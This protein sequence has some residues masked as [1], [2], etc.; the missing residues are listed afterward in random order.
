MSESHVE[1]EIADPKERFDDVVREYID[2]VNQQVGAYM[3]ALAGFAGHYTRVERQVHRVIR[4]SRRVNPAVPADPVVWTSYEDPTQP[5]V[6]HNR[7]VRS[8]DYLAINARGGSNEQQQARATLVFLFT[9]WEEDIR[10]RLAAS[11]GVEKNAVRSDIMADLRTIRH[12][13]LHAK[14]ILRPDKHKTLKVLGSL[15]EPDRPL[16]VAYDDMHKIFVL[17]K[18]DCARIMF[19]WLGVPDPAGQAA[20][21]VDV[22]IQRQAPPGGP[23]RRDVP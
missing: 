7:I 11:S 10:P 8:P 20:Q 17:V 21:L 6:I 3:D 18:R 14:S 2:F 4:S 1:H 16:H 23:G 12:A 19:E 9:Y 15:F 13:I 5:D 22:A